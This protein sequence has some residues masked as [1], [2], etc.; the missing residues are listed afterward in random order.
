MGCALPDGHVP[1][2]LLPSSVDCVLLLEACQFYDGLSQGCPGQT[3]SLLLYLNLQLAC[4]HPW[5]L[6]KTVPAQRTLVSFSV[7]HHH[8]GLYP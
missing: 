1:P 5:A 6:L 8:E 4:R 7:D 2:T 3:F